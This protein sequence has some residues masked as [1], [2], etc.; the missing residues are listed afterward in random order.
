MLDDAG[1]PDAII[2]ASSDLDE[3]LISSLKTQG[4]QINSWGVGT[5]LIT[6]R[7]CPSFGGVYKLVAM[8]DQETGE[9]IPRIK[10]SEDIEKITNPGN[11]TVFRLYSKETGK[12]IGDLI[13]LVGEHFP[14]DQDILLFDPISTWKQT[15]VKAGTFTIRE[16]LVPVFEKGICIYNERSV[17][18]IAET[19]SEELDTLWEETRRLVNPSEVY[20]DLSMQLYTM[21]KELLLQ[22]A[23]I[24]L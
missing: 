6:A 12:I 9:F 4:A 20:V 14:E 7:D 10:V 17:S 23:K 24:N 1:F 2:S 3:Y 18:Q 8:Q 22:A 15:L 19:C 21:R 11:K 16:L 5:N 13:S